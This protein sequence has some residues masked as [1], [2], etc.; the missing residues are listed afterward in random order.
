MVTL[1]HVAFEKNLLVGFLLFHV[2]VNKMA[3]EFRCAFELLGMNVC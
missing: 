3:V 2:V 1:R